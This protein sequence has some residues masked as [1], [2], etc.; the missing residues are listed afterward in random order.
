M[1]RD[2]KIYSYEVF[3]K[4]L[5]GLAIAGAIVGGLILVVGVAGSTGAPQEAAA[6]AIAVAFG[7]LPYCLARATHGLSSINARAL[8]QDQ[9]QKQ[10]K[11]LASI[12]NKLPELNSSALSTPTKPAVIP[13]EV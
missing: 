11:L 5:Y 4:L 13:P 6:A 8:F 12:A 1:D 7:V 9:Q 10:I 3:V 2:D